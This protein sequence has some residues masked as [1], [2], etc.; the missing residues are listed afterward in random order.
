M[1]ILV[2]VTQDQQGEDAIALGLALAKSRNADVT[3]AHIYPAAFDFVGVAHVDHEWRQFLRD[4]AQEILD[5]A[6]EEVAEHGSQAAGG[7]NINFAMAGHKSSGVGLYELAA[8][9]GAKAVVIG[10]APG[11]SEGRIAIGSTANQLFHESPVAVAVAP[12]GYANWAPD[13]IG[14]V[15]LAYRKGHNM[16]K[17]LVDMVRDSEAAEKLNLKIVTVLDEPSHLRRLSSRSKGKGEQLLQTLRAQ[18]QERLDVAVADVVE[19]IGQVPDS[20]IIEADGFG[21]AIARFNF[22]D[23]DL[24][25]MGTPRS[26]P[27]RRVFLNDAT[28]TMIRS[29]T[30][31]IIVSPQRS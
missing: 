9:R 1:E 2:G 5:W 21:R 8:T 12:M 28:Y 10:S 31:P 6:R 3:F 14:R 26:A 4:E 20:E 19:Q 24:L 25:M 29:A 11:G 7:N 27:L 22:E 30:V 15:V 23:D 18:A 17:A 16:I 13:E